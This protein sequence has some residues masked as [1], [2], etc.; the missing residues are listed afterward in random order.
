MNVRYPR[1]G[2]FYKAAL[3]WPAML[4]LDEFLNRDIDLCQAIASGDSCVLLI[5]PM[6]IV[7]LENPNALCGVFQMSKAKWYKRTLSLLRLYLPIFLNKY[8]LDEHF[9]RTW[10]TPCL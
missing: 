8:L 9:E 6:S 4:Q 3:T 5:V 2:Y 1:V 10:I 7:S